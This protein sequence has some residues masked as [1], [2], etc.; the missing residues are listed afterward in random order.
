ML[1]KSRRN[2]SK[3]YSMEEKA[4]IN[5]SMTWAKDMKGLNK[6]G[7]LF[8]IK[9]AKKIPDQKVGDKSERIF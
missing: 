6:L 2:P 4:K 8:G 5:S 3:V 7:C 1:L 9:P